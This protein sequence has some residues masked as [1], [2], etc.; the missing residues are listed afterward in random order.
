MPGRA[1]RYP[2]PAWED[3]PPRKLPKILSWL[4]YYLVLSICTSFVTRCLT[5]ALEFARNKRAGHEPWRRLDTVDCDHVG[6]RWNR[7]RTAC[8]PV[9]GGSAQAHS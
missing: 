9:A 6:L 4:A 3:P 1:K 7:Q 2:S 5:K 8:A